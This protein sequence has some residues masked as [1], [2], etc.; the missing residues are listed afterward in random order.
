MGDQDLA[1][2]VMSCAIKVGI[3]F[4]SRGFLSRWECLLFKTLVGSCNIKS[5]YVCMYVCITGRHVVF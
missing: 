2:N 4:C 3:V 1:M 5:M